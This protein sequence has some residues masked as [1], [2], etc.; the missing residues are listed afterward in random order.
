[1]TRGRLLLVAVTLTAVCAAALIGRWTSPSNSPAHP[2]TID[3][4]FSQAMI[5]HHQQA[6]LMTRVV[7]GRLSPG[8]SQVA[9]AIADGQLREMGVMQGWLLQWDRPVTTT[10]DAGTSM[11]HHDAM[12][13]DELTQLT[14]TPTPAATDQLFASLML[15][16]H[17]AGISMAAAAVRDSPTP[18]VQS[19]ARQM[20]VD[21]TQEAQM[22]TTLTTPAS[23]S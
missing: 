18:M 16:H 12:P 23:G 11:D 5:A 15:S 4:N 21:E 20:I 17:R 10:G 13:G 1:M 19:L 22:I 6:I 7:D 9:R 3:V 2:Q 8:M 14:Q